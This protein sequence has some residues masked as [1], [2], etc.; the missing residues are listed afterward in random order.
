[1]V[2]IELKVESFSKKTVVFAQSKGKVVALRTQVK[3][4]ELLLQA[5]NAI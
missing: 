5:D 1:M 4:N 3:R 2:T